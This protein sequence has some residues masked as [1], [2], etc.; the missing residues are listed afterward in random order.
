ML[1]PVDNNNE[2]HNYW[3]FTTVIPNIRRRY[4]SDDRLCRVLALAKLW[5]VFDETASEDLPLAE[6]E[7]VKHSFAQNFGDR[8]GNPVVKIQLEIINVNGNL[9]IVA[10][11]NNNDTNNDGNAGD[12]AGPQQQQQQQQQQQGNQS[13]RNAQTQMMSLFQHQHQETLQR[14][15]VMQA[16]IVAQRA[17]MQ[18]MFDRV[19][20]N[21]R[22]YGGTVHSAFARSNRQEEQRRD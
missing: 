19:I 20:T 15:E 22:R 10:A 16:D 9:Q 12:N 1:K 2:V 4:E 18:Q 7:R 13:R 14:L 3:L 11:A 17:W 21:Q 8:D 6:V 5:A